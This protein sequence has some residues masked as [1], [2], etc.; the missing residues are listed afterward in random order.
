MRQMRVSDGA[1]SW[2]DFDGATVASLPSHFRMLE[3]ERYTSISCPKIHL[4]LYNSV[5]R[6]HGLDEAHLIMFFLMSLSGA[7]QRWF[8]ALDASCCRTWD[9]LT[10]EFL[11][12]FALNTIIDVSRREIEALRQGSEESVTSFISG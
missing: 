11:I 5:M 6:A 10:Q 4:R 7:A 1:I 9:D 3:I 12:Q 2:D 8:A